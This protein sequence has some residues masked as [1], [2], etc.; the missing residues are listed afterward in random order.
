MKYCFLSKVLIYAV[1]FFL[2]YSCTQSN[3]SQKE[4]TTSI[5]IADS[6]AQYNAIKGI[7]NLD[8]LKLNFPEITPEQEALLLFKKGEIYYINDLYV[9][10]ILEHQKATEL[11]AKQKDTYNKTRSLITLSAANLRLKNIEKAQEFALEA[12]QNANL[13]ED[14]RLLAKANNQLFQ[15]HF[16][17]EDYPKAMEYIKKA[18]R[19]FVDQKDTTSI[20]AIKGNIASIY[21]K[22]KE[23]NKALQ[24]YQEALQLGQNSK[25]PQTIVSI[26]NN[27][28]YTYIETEKYATA[29]TFLEGAIKL[30]QN[31]GAINGAPYKGLGYAYFVNNDFETAKLYYNEA[32]TIYQQ[33]KNIPEQIQILDKLITIAIRG[34]NSEQALNYQL[35]RD[36]L[37]IDNQAKET[38][39]LLH[40]ATVKYQAKEKEADLLYQKQ[41][42]KKNRLLYGS[43]LVAL[44]LLLILVGSYLYITKLKAANRASQ[45]EQ[46]L[47]RVQMNP[48]FIFN[49]LAA[50]Q[51]VTLDQDPIKSSNYI[52]KFSKLIR[53]NFDYVRKEEI[54]LEQ[55]ISM[56]G[57]YIE[58]QQLRFHNSFVYQLDLAKDQDIKSLKVPPMLLQP[59]LENAIEYGLKDKKSG[60]VLTLQIFKENNALCF[61]VTDNGIGRSH[62][63][64]EQKKSTELHATDIFIERLKLRKKGEE[65]TFKIEDLYNLEQQAVGTK[66]SFKIYFI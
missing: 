4:F 39:S 61:V 45:L 50:I 47:L 46:S 24:T 63:A 18:D 8:S 13:L 36:Q 44:V 1:L 35:Q 17:L 20:I 6:L 33:N 49:T 7:Q 58:T 2:L 9:E 5:D 32:F 60:G 27:I 29:A 66:V 40:F 38:E 28:G 21:L 30:N 10:S 3:V 64:K 62:Q 34:N 41:L 57:N 14:K 65:K 12:L 25:S 42:N 16:S 31:I 54:A 53:Q 43:V 52:A 11:F 37:Q 22:L 48:H 15:L 51:N 56:I 55:E 59:F 19:I 23:Y 26:L